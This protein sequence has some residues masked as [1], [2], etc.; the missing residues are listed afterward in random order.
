MEWELLFKCH[1]LFN[2]IVVTVLM[3]LLMDKFTSAIVL[4]YHEF[5]RM[6][7]IE[8]KENNLVD[9]ASSRF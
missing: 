4:T 3:T 7:I 5:I 6:P 9:Y 1:V 8:R 2:V